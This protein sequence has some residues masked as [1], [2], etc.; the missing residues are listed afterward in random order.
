VIIRIGESTSV[1]FFSQAHAVQPDPGGRLAQWLDETWPALIRDYAQTI[2]GRNNA[3]QGS[4][5]GVVNWTELPLPK[6]NSWL[7][8][9]GLSRPARGVFLV[10]TSEADRLRS[11]YPLTDSYHLQIGE[12]EDSV[13]QWRVRVVAVFHL[14][15]GDDDG[16][17]LCAVW[18]TGATG[19]D[20]GTAGVAYTWADAMR[21]GQSHETIDAVYGIPARWPWLQRIASP[22]VLADVAAWSVGRRL[23]EPLRI[24]FGLKAMT[25]EQADER[26]TENLS[27]TGGRMLAQATIEPDWSDRYQTNNRLAFTPLINGRPLGWPVGTALSDS[28]I[29]YQFGESRSEWPVLRTANRSF[30]AGVIDASHSAAQLSSA[31]NAMNDAWHAA[32]RAWRMSNPDALLFAGISDWINSG[33]EDYVVWECWPKPV[34]RVVPMPL[35]YGCSWHVATDPTIEPLD[36]TILVKEITPDN[37]PNQQED[38]S[39][40]PKQ[41]W[42]GIATVVDYGQ[43]TPM[44]TR[45]AFPRQVEVLILSRINPGIEDFSASYPVPANWCQSLNCYVVGGWPDYGKRLH[46]AEQQTRLALWRTDWMIAHPGASA[47]PNWNT[48]P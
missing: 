28:D 24:G 33:Q 36:Q 35:N 46:E 48:G 14:A 12:D 43:Y 16:E 1:G 18:L 6:I 17:S 27:R 30:R 15:Q 39:V 44:Q 4:C 19:G 11:T 45:A 3:S 25:F 10:K 34:T 13:V 20:T 40:E 47:P 38:G 9:T 37:V 26:D 42:V 2:G 31:R 23:V 32:D 41:P 7:V 8:P 22:N 21:L 29:N 5:P